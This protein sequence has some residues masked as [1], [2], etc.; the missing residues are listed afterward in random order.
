MSEQLKV[1]V[2]AVGAPLG[3][4]IVKALRLS[5]LKPEIHVADISS[6]AAGLHLGEKHHVVLPLVRDPAYG[7]ALADYITKHGIRVIFPTIAAEHDYFAANESELAAL[8]VQIATCSPR[9]FA[10]CN[11][12]YE[13]MMALR[14]GGLAAPDTLV[15]QD[16]EKVEA[17]LARNRLPVVLKPRSGASS[18]HV[19]IA[20]DR[21][22][23]DALT[24]AFESGYFVAQEFLHDHKD[25][26]VGVYI[27]RDG[28]FRDAFA[29]ERN[30]KFGLSYSGYVC[31]NEAIRQYAM[32]AAVLVGAT[33]SV[34]VQL[35]LKDGAACAYE[36]NPRL[37]STTCIRAHFGFNEP[38]LIL[39][40]LAG[41]PLEHP[42]KAR[43]G[44]FA[45]YWEE[46]YLR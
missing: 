19:F 5:S 44:E 20:K 35:K 27:S 1:L 21:K 42:Q 7:K 3:Q 40:D 23:L 25:Y 41:I 12:K 15:C 16:A 9:T 11:D 14:R 10:V 26:T 22:Q 29:L 46:I 4:S 6:L 34:N 37:S 28:K 36:I 45:R 2:M 32:D 43:T 39:R 24:G 31:D 18:N 8:G 30:L 13:S 17:F 38:D 33:F